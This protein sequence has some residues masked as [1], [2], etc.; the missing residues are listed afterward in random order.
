MMEQ[1]PMQPSSSRHFSSSTPSALMHATNSACMSP[2]RADLQ[3]LAWNLCV[4]RALVGE[5]RVTS[6]R[7]YDG[8]QD[9][10][11]RWSG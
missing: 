10:G 11:F 4:R 7:S 1:R 8:R 5:G 3:L 2:A 6:R 9:R